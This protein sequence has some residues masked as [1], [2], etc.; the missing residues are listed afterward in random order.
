M[1]DMHSHILP[2][3]DDGARTPGDALALLRAAIRDGV[4]TQ[5]LTPHIHL[6]RY[7]NRLDLIRAEFEKFNNAIQRVGL[8]VE[9]DFAAE[10]RLDDAV[11]ELVRNEDIP[12]LGAWKGMDV[13]LLEFPA[14]RIPV[15]ALNIVRWLYDR[16]IIS[17][18]AH[19]E[20][21]LELQ[22][23]PE[24]IRPFLEQGCMLQLTAGS[25]TGQFGRAAFETAV[26]YL[27]YNIVTLLATDCHN[28]KYR[29]PNLRM[30][31][32]IAANL[33]GNEI[34]NKLVNINPRK[35]RDGLYSR[36]QQAASGF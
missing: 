6:D 15:G 33:V 26:I 13:M 35:L 31:A 1:I 25:L 23:K 14:N 3:I 18:L 30:G 24:K 36:P 21:N 22:N 27:R 19:P 32:T 9:L 10:V 29:P 2:G 20:R 12:F 34:A 7:N 8:P 4:S 17:M 5:V 16:G 11:R 28:M